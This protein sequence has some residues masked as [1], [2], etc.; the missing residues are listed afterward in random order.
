MYAY[1]VAAL[2]IQE[3]TA[4]IIKDSCLVQGPMIAFIT[5]INGCSILVSYIMWL[6]PKRLFL[7]QWEHIGK[8]FCRTEQRINILGILVYLIPSFCFQFPFIH[9]ETQISFSRLD[10][11]SLLCC[12]VCFPQSSYNRTTMELGAVCHPIYEENPRRRVSVI[13][14]SL[15]GAMT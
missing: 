1:F 6:P 12:T 9:Q 10:R 5:M 15:Y 8:D 7:F 4:L 13:L 11:D 2:K 3:N 14:D